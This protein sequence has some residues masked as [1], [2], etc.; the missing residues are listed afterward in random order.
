MPIDIA[1]MRSRLWKLPEE[2]GIVILTK[3][4]LIELETAREVLA[5][6]P[7]CTQHGLYCPDHWKDWIICRRHDQEEME[8]KPFKIGDRVRIIGDRCGMMSER[9]HNE[10]GEIEE[11]NARGNI[12]VNVGETFWWYPASSL[13]LAEEPLAI[14]DE[15][16]IRGPTDKGND[17]YRAGTFVITG[18]VYSPGSGFIFSG[19]GLSEWWP[20]SSLR[21][22]SNSDKIELS[23]E[24]KAKIRAVIESAILVAPDRLADIEKQ[25]ADL[26]E[27]FQEKDEYDTDVRDHQTKVNTGLLVRV[28]DLEAW[29]KSFDPIP[30]PGSEL[31]VGDWVVVTGKTSLNE[32]GNQGR[33]FRIASRN[34]HSGN[35]SG[36]NEAWYAARDL[37]KLSDAEIAARLNGDQ[38]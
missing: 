5:L 1:D 32:D 29:K 35:F 36:Q 38:A 37:R 26:K 19:D 6:I 34:G 13:E 17:L 22:I 27:A 8:G 2:D 30:D 21:K 11:I 25:L 24:T 12:K 16:V 9:L 31:Q 4:A 3:A 23:K 33:I 10:A 15:V 20:D 7:E 28:H 14:G 18:K